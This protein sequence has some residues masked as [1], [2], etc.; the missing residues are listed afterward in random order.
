MVP[1]NVFMRMSTLSY[2][3]LFFSLQM[4]ILPIQLLSFS[5]SMTPSVSSSL[6]DVRIHP[7]WFIIGFHSQVPTQ[8][9]LSDPKNEIVEIG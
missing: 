6:L 7:D 8:I 4:L 9:W 2:E 1:G 3:R 5:P